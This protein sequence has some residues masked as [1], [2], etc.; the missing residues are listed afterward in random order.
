MRDE[1]VAHLFE[2]AGD[3][4]RAG[5]VLDMGC[6][7]GWWIERMAEAGVAPSRIYGLDLLPERIRSAAARTPG[8]QLQTGDVRATAF[9]S[10]R[11]SVVSLLLVLSSLADRA[12]MQAALG[13]AFRLTSEHGVVVVWEPRIPNPL[14]RAAR[15]VPD[16]LVSGVLGPATT[17]VTLTLVPA[18]ARQLRQRDQYT[19][20]AR[21]SP[22]RTHR[23]TVHRPHGA[24]GTHR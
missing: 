1:L 8:A 20:L 14:N 5:D 13:E 22:L 10:G 23:L 12:A 21:L 11:F 18:L 16:A 17:R 7:S 3:E 2:I 19:R 9:E 15:Q 4:L 24:P 6:G